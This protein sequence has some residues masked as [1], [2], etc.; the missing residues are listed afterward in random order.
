[1]AAIARVVAILA[2]TLGAA[3]AS[4][5]VLDIVGLAGDVGTV[6]PTVAIGVVLLF[7]HSAIKKS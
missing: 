5:S 1:M 3:L 6:T 7:W 4:V 2:V